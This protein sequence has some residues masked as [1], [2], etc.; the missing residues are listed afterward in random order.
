[1]YVPAG[2]RIRALRRSGFGQTFDLSSAFTDC[3]DPANA[4][5]AACTNAPGLPQL[6]VG[7]YGSGNTALMSLPASLATDASQIAASVTGATSSASLSAAL[8]WILG[9]VVLFVIAG[10][11]SGKK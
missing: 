11:Y 7:V 4:S 9:G 10:A 1:V 8:P 5:L 6:P 2:R 3:T